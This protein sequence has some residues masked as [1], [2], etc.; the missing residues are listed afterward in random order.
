MISLFIVANKTYARVYLPLTSSLLSLWGQ[1]RN[2]HASFKLSERYKL[3]RPTKVLA[4]IV[5]DS[6]E[7]K[8]QT[9][10]ATLSQD[11]V[12]RIVT[13]DED[14]SPLALSTIRQE[15][16]MSGIADSIANINVTNPKTAA[17]YN[18]DLKL[19]EKPFQIGFGN[20]S[21]FSYTHYAD[22]GPRFG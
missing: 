16:K 4:A 7:G 13:D 19:W 10:K 8:F 18:L 1:Q 22:F 12:Y 17:F 5:E 20:N 21:K 2:Q 6:P 15:A 3:D 11:I 14:S 9:F